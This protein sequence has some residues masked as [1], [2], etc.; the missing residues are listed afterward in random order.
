MTKP[1]GP[2]EPHLPVGR[3][4]DYREEYCAQVIEWGKDGWSRAELANGL[5]ISRQTL[6]NWEAAHP[7][8]LDATS[9][10]RDASLAWWEQQGREGVTKSHDQFNHGL[11]GKCMGGRFPEEPY[12]TTKHEHSGPNG[13]PIPA[14]LEGLSESQL[15]QLAKRLGVAGGD[16]PPSGGGEGDSPA[17]G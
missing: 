13:G 3:P 11:Y 14:R 2:D 17:E 12:R 15:D 8:F 5:D 1:K 6:A 10:A 7:E 9:R 16:G 4:T